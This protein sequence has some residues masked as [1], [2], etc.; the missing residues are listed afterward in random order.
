MFALRGDGYAGASLAL[1]ERV[2]Q[3][4]PASLVEWRV[5]E[6]TRNHKIGVHEVAGALSGFAGDL[7]LLQGIDES[8]CT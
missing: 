1:G 7:L 4:R 6:P 8:A 3:S 2:E 5:A